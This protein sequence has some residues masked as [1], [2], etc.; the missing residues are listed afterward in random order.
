METFDDL[1]KESLKAGLTIDDISKM[2]DDA[3][4]NNVNKINSIRAIAY[5]E[6]K[7][8]LERAAAFIVLHFAESCLGDKIE[9]SDF[10]DHLLTILKD[11][12]KTYK[13]AH[14]LADKWAN[15]LKAVAE[16]NDFTTLS[17][18]LKNNLND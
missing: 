7:S 8:N 17:N 12:Y 6:G 3:L 5:D 13:V 4:N 14:T 1:I 18:W 15:S 10:Y 2:F 11:I 16:D 9:F